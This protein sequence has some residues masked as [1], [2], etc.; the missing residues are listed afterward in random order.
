MKERNAGLDVL[1][2]VAMIMIV[3]LHI[4]GQGDFITNTNNEEFYQISIILKIICIV[5]VNCYVL[6]TGYFQSNSTF[7]MKKIIIIWIKVIFYSISI[8]AIIILLGKREFSISECI[9][10]VF[11]ITTNSYWFVNC[12]LLLYI[13]SP[14]LN[15]LI[16]ALD[17]KEFQKLII[18]LLIV[19]CVCPSILPANFTLDKTAG[20]GII[21][22]IVLY[23]VGAYIR[24]HIKINYD[25][26]INLFMYFL[27]S[28][29]NCMIFFGIN[30]MS[31]VINIQDFS[32][33]LYNYNFITVFIATVFLFLYFKNLNIK[34]MKLNNLI[35]KIA[36]LTFAV[37]IIH[38][39]IVLNEV[40]YFDILKLNIL[41][42]NWIQILIIPLVT[43][44]IFIIC[45]LI[46]RV[47]KDTIQKRIVNLVGK[48]YNGFKETKFYKIIQ[49]KLLQ[50]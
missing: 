46:E 39:Q 38:T 7:K 30:Y 14:F 18:I 17:K 33:R 25:N 36:P 13:I 49:F 19:F 43:I 40:L 41:W 48:I 42:N 5:A 47:T 8:Y 34:N 4:L 28:I 29:I 32:I 2:I 9:K 6:I 23:F 24:L 3:I 12:Y 16:K 21:W 15:K 37:Y 27:I 45:I 22:F 50:N 44:G 10:S 31:N 20:Y 11:P 26:H 35:N 1:R